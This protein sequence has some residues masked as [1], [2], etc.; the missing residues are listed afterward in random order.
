[1]KKRHY[2]GKKSQEFFTK[3][4]SQIVKS[5]RDDPFIFGSE[6]E[7]VPKSSKLSRELEF[8]KYSFKMPN[9][10]GASG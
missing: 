1:M 6:S 7:N 9:L 2:K 8:Q 5:L 3:F 10:E 4:I